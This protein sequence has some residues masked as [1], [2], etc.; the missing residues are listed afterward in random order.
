MAVNTTLP[1]IWGRE[2][3]EVI[4]A[5][6]GYYH[7]GFEDIGGARERDFTP[8]ALD[9]VAGSGGASIF[10]SFLE[11]ELIPF[12]DAY[13]RTIPDDR[14]IWGASLGGLFVL[15][16]FFE[17]PHLFHRYI[18]S[19]PA[20]SRNL[21]YFLNRIETL[22]STPRGEVRKLFVSVGSDETP[23]YLSSLD[24][25]TQALLRRKDA[26]LHLQSVTLDKETHVSQISRA[27]VTGLRAVFA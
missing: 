15:Y 17:R 11:T 14:S 27:Y 6:I 13:Y 21:P 19:S 2:V 7:Q 23:G 8:R 25:F 16:C 1:L 26:S 18:G 22:S 5:G 9:D 4:L 24:A 10:L 3:P 20:L 12:V